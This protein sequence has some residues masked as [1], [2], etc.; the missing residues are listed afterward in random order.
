MLYC[1]CCNVGCEFDGAVARGE[2]RAVLDI[3][4]KPRVGHEECTFRYIL[5]VIR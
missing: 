2:R 4:K 3:I 5:I 1:G